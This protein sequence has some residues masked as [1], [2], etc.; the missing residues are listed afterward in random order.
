MAELVLGAK[1]YAL[2]RFRPATTLD[3]TFA[4]YSAPDDAEMRMIA[5]IFRP[6]VQELILR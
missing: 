1:R 2:Q 6:N 5:E 4:N 3:P